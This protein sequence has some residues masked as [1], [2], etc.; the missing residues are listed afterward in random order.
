MANYHHSTGFLW[1]LDHLSKLGEN[2]M[3]YSDILRKI[4]GI[5]FFHGFTKTI[6]KRVFL[7]DCGF[8]GIITEIQ[9][10]R[11]YG[12]F[13]SIGVKFFWSDYYNVNYDYSRDNIRISEKT[14]IS[15]LGAL[16]FDS[17]TFNIELEQTTVLLEQ[18]IDEYSRL[19]FVEEFCQMIY[20]RRDF[21][22]VANPDFKNKDVSLAIVNM[23]L[24]RS[25]MAF[26]ILKNGSID[27]HIASQ[28][29][30]H[31]NDIADFIRVLTILINNC[32]LNLAKN[33]GVVLE[34][35]NA[36][37]SDYKVN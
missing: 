2:D 31:T 7:K 33:L 15:P 5:V 12:V 34:P 28:L 30:D 20:E 10:F 14:S 24:G 19:V 37:W 9:P 23:I 27:N 26:A 11:N 13:I 6:N 17:P 29:L 3:K 32:R 4:T 21:V 18:K 16:M 8:F 25:E 35:I 1:Q 22:A 36:L